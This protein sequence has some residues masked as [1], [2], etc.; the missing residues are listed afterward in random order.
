MCLK[1]LEQR[2]NLTH[3]VLIN[4]VFLQMKDLELD[5]IQYYLYGF[6]WTPKEN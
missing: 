5:R 6:F 4:I 1:E 2:E 3:L